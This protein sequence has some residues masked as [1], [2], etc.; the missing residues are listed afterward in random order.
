[1]TA[2]TPALLAAAAGVGFGHAVLPD[3]WVPLAVLGRTQRYSLGRVARLSGLAGVAH[4]IVSMV[5]GAIVIAVGLQLRHTVQSAQNIIIGTVLILTG[6]GFA[7]IEITG[8]GHSHGA[9]HDHGGG[10]AHGTGHDYGGG[11]G[12]GAGRE[13]SGG[14]DRP[15][16][17]WGS[18]ALPTTEAG[19]GPT[20]G[21]RSLRGL[22]AVMVPFGAAASPDLTILP[23]LA[24]CRGKTLERAKRPR[25]GW[26][27][28]PFRCEWVALVRSGFSVSVGSDGERVEVV[29]EDRPAGPDL[30]ALVAFEAAAVEAVAAFEVADAA[31]GAGS[32]AL[33]PPLGAFGAGLLAA[34][35]E[36][37]LGRE[38]A[39]GLAGRAGCGS[40]RRALPRAG[41]PEP[42]EFGDGVGQQR[43][44][45]RVARLLWRAA[46]SARAR[47]AGCSRSPRR[48]G[49]HSRTRSA[50]RACPCG[51]AGRRG[52]RARPA[53]L[54]SARPRPAA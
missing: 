5:L 22:A 18:W 16:R 49:S 46:G 39:E 1:M 29:G 40:R 2:T 10:H 3:H 38:A 6:V 19:H 51:S 28:R 34:G 21:E 23:V 8:R 13:H 12:H 54:G 41:E 7:I 30:L 31:L 45:G 17:Q 52:L 35:D 43:V 53:G 48:A 24:T 47:R 14:P 11:H 37:P 4:V 44:L 25:P 27:A 9:G 36:H 33:Q 20:H 42:L 15:A 50:C 32:V 26:W